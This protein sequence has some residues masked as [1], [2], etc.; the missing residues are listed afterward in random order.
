MGGVEGRGC[1][2]VGMLAGSEGGRGL[3]EGRGMA[4]RTQASLL[5]EQLLVCHGVDGVGEG[6]RRTGRGKGRTVISGSTPF[7]TARDRHNSAIGLDI[8][9]NAVAIE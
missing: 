2:C 8:R 1:N 5:V 7:T 9:L 6:E 3:D 4:K